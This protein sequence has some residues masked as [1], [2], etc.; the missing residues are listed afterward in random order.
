MALFRDNP[1]EA[2]KR[3]NLTPKEKNK[4]RRMMLGGICGLL[5]VAL[6]L[7]GFIFDW[8]PQKGNLQVWSFGYMLFGFV[9][10]AVVFVTGVSKGRDHRPGIIEMLAAGGRR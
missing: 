10:Y 5:S 7:L 3:R 1:S 9:V 6:V 4:Y 8:I 2:E